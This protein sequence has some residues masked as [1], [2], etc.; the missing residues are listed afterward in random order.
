MILLPVLRLPEVHI[1]IA[2]EDAGESSVGIV[3]T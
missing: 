2:K 1:Q 3:F